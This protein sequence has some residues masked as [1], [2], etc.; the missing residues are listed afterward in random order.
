MKKRISVFFIIIFAAIYCFSENYE[1]NQRA[2]EM[3]NYLT[4]QTQFI[5]DSK[6]NKVTLEETY[7]KIINNI[8]PSAVDK[9]T[10]EQLTYI[11]D[12]IHKLRLL[13]A[14]REQLQILFENDQAQA[15]S[16]AMPN[17]TYLLSTVISGDPLK[18][19]ASIAM[20]GLSSWVNYNNAK[21]DSIIANLK[22]KWE[23]D[24]Q[25]M[26]S[27]HSIRKNAF[28]YMIRIVNSYK[29]IKD[30]YTLNEDSVKEFISFQMTEN[31]HQRKLRLEGNQHKFEKYGQYWGLLAK[32]Y[33]EIDDFKSCLKAIKKYEETRTSI[34]RYDLEFA[35]VLPYAVMAAEKVY[36]AKDK[37][38]IY[39]AERYLKLLEKE[40]PT[41]QWQ[42]RYFIS[43]AYILLARN[44]NDNSY[45]NKAYS[46]VKLDLPTLASE[47]ENGSKTI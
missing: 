21:N 36:G 27:I 39:E 7:N 4:M 37:K 15:L 28:T 8:A 12:E 46:I 47:Q 34:F 1:Q 23:L 9:K 25:E 13:E 14:N 31:P 41:N 3:L 17:P 35:N 26:Q 10:K 6:N 43:Q 33:F 22:S 44:S 40:T 42:M 11:L 24:K 38:Y 16:K 20:T 18:T 5:I 19:V 30:S 2:V 29:G 32:T 45:L